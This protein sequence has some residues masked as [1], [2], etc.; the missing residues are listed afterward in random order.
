M[1]NAGFQPDKPLSGT[2]FSAT[3]Y[4]LLIILYVLYRFPGLYRLYRKGLA[5]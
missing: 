1:P 4:A 3:T 5:E 2:T